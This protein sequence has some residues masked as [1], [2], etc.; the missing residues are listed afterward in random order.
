MLRIVLE[1]DAVKALDRM[2]EPFASTIWMKI[3]QL[4]DDPSALRNMV[5][6]LRGTGEMRLRVGNWRVFYAIQGETLHV[7]A[8]EHRRDAYR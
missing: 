4:A 1:R 7:R 5:K 6:Q 3:R 2:P 8:I